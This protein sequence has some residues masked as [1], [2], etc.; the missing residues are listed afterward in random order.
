MINFQGEE[1]TNEIRKILSKRGAR[2]YFIGI[3]GISMSALAL[4]LK[5]NGVFVAGSDIRQSE[6]TDTLIKQGVKVRF[7]HS[8][9][10]I[11]SFKPDIAVFSLAIG[12]SNCEYNA[13]KNMNVLLISRAELLG[14]LLEDY[15]IK[16]GISG[17]HGKSTV[18]SMLGAV[19]KEA[20]LSPTVLCGADIS[21][22]AGLS[23]GEHNYLVY[24][25]CEYRDSFL[26][27][28]ADVQV[29]LNL[30]L[31]HTDYFKSEE[32]IRESFLKA[33]N[34][35]RKCTVLNLD[36]ENLA[37]ISDKIKTELHTFSSR[38]GAE[39]RYEPTFIDKGNYSF[40]LYKENNRIGEYFPGAKGRFNLENAVATAISA[41][42]CG[43]KYEDSAKAIAE[44]S[45]I[46]RRL[47]LLTKTPFDVFYDYA[48]HPSEIASV[49]EA[50]VAMGYK[51][52]VAVFAP[53]TYSRTKSFE[54]RFVTELAKFNTVYVTDIYGARES[55]IVGISSSALASAVS[56]TG[57]VCHAVSDR[58]APLIVRE[59][60]QCAPDC[61]LLMGAGNLDE[62]KKEILKK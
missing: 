14:A 47:E 5:E 15:K 19:L 53:H 36:S 34:S 55:A 60:K 61:V 9:E 58:E 10:A 30:E 41:D 38:D 49:R 28:R 33:A 40:K 48:H 57:G 25:S 39:Y 12:E 20:N 11:M 2:V 43:V 3:G 50:L 18:T 56:Y 4:L 35:A 32:Q 52:I 31:D 24:E 13:A 1:K 23:S 37:M 54:S 46:K 45:G 59:I 29:L 17:S 26:K 27:L 22:G 6:I 21:G 7:S 8:K 51:N 42:V 62:Y 44:F 16:I